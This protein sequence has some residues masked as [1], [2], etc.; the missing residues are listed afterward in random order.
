M[1]QEA[2]PHSTPMITSTPKGRISDPMPSLAK[3]TDTACMIPPASWIC[4]PGT[5]MAMATLPRM[6]SPATVVAA[7]STDPG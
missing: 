3:N 2:R 6:D 5:T 4:L 7:T 1:L